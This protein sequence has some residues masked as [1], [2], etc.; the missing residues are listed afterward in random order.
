VTVTDEILSLREEV[1]TCPAC[2]SRDRVLCL[3]EADLMQC[4]T[5]DVLYVSPRPT[6]AAIRAFYSA[7]GRYDRWDL[8]RGRAAMW[9][10]RVDRV[11]RLV[12]SGGRLLDVGTGQ[13]DFAALAK[14]H[15]EVEATE[16][17]SEGARL[18]RERH[19]VVVHHGDLID[20]GLPAERY[21]ALTLWHVL[22]H[23]VNP[24]EVAAECRRLLKPRGLMVI[25]VPNA[26]ADFRFTRRLWSD[27][28]L[29]ARNRP[30]RHRCDVPIVDQVLSLMLGR[31][32]QRRIAISRLDLSRAAAEIHL[33]HFTLETLS[34]ML[35]VLGFDMT[36]R[37]VDDHSPD[38][39]ILAR[40]RHRHQVMMYSLSGRAA[41]G[42]VFVAAR[43]NA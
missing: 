11:R 7:H 5:C 25:A 4:V 41:A 23:L 42:A 37:G 10:R 32:P 14:K 38:A 19:G 43:K 40:I 13:G 31:T 2:G 29:F 17:S 35:K 33:T 18:A 15:F 3:P 28:L 36:A 30:L 20:L 22:E 24:R 27:A 39:G 1:S 9:L 12:P 34:R 6:I 8:E 21:D 16:I 26:D